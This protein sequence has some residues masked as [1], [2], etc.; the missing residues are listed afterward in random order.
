MNGV[1]TSRSE[2]DVITDRGFNRTQAR[3]QATI[4]HDFDVRRYPMDD[5]VVQLYLEDTELDF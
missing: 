3:V 2:N 4:F 1:I 5:H